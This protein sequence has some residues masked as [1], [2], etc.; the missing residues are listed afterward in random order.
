[1]DLTRSG[2]YWKEEKEDGEAEK[3]RR[4]EMNRWGGLLSNGCKRKQESEEGIK[5]VTEGRWEE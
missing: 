2:V 1:M 3:K 5:G 4:M